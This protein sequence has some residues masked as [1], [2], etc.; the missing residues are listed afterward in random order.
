M[1]LHEKLGQLT[2]TQ[3]K[4]LSST[5][6]E[7]FRKLMFEDLETKLL[8]DVTELIQ[9]TRLQEDDEINLTH[10]VILTSK[11]FEAI[12]DELLTRRNI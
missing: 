10:S 2:E 12:I 8:K 11:E 7:N 6:A 3:T 5:I 9:N 1:N 4:I